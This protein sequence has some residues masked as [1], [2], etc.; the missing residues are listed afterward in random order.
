MMENIIGKERVE[1]HSIQRYN[2]KVLGSVSDAP[3]PLH[4]KEDT[5]SKEIETS[6]PLSDEV[7]SITRI[8]EGKQNQF[9]EELLKKTDELTSSVIKLQIQIEKQE[10]DFSKRLT[11]AVERE[12]ENAYTQG[13]QKAKEESETSLSEV[14]SRYLKSITHLDTLY[15]SFDERLGK[16]ESEMSVSAFEIAKEVI[17]KEIAFSSSQVAVALSKALL[18]EVKD[19][20]KIELRVNPKDFEALKEVYANEEKIKV[21]SDD[22]V[23]QGGI[24]IFSDVGNLDGNVAM[25]LDKVKYLLHEN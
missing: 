11:E 21:I 1:E 7:V 3:I 25:R 22:A 18:Q 2:F 23:A 8:E 13:Y 15:K 24:V 9:I 5:Y 10:E 17:K 14:K 20:I 6:S 16:V 19:A 12:R 4:V